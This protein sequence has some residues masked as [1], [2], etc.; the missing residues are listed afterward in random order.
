MMHNQALLPTYLKGIGGWCDP[1]LE[2]AKAMRL[3]KTP[4]M[5]VSERRDSSEA[6]RP[7]S[8]H[9]QTQQQQQQQQQ[10]QRHQTERAKPRGV[11]NSTL[12]R[13]PPP[14]SSRNATPAVT[15]TK[16]ATA[17]PRHRQFHAPKIL[18]AELLGPK[19]WHTEREDWVRSPAATP[20]AAYKAMP[21]LAPPAR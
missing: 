14:P 12:T 4:A 19:S 3:P 8:G 5:P 7:T 9:P 18:A 17:R 13:A 2:N 20:N 10:H 6:T 15:T 16:S 11:T 1:A 21:L